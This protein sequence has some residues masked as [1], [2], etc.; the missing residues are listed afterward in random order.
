MPVEEA[1][2]RKSEGEHDRIEGEPAEFHRAV[3]EAYLM[4]AKLYS[5]RVVVIDARAGIQEIHARVKTEVG[6][7]L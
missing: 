5:R 3:R 2:A 1:L 6:R 7:F 4:L